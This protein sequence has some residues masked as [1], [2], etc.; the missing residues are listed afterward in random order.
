MENLFEQSLISNEE[1]YKFL[2]NNGIALWDVIKSCDIISASDSSIKNVVPNNLKT[3]TDN[4]N[5]KMIFT[6]GT[7]AHSLYNKYCYSSLHKEDIC[8]PSTSP[9]N[10]RKKLCELTEDYRII[11]NYL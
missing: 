5:I 1:K 11:L 8:L 6:A 9:A 10:A 7:T 4:C 3:I 2:I